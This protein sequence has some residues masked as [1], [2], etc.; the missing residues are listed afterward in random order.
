MIYIIY[1]VNMK[2][3]ERKL[4]ILILLFKCLSKKFFL[5]VFSRKAVFLQQ[6]RS[7]D[8]KLI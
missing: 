5:K 8:Y 7:S 2:S 4:E 1:I 3:E 6:K